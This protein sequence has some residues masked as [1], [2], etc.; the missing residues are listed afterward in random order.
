MAETVV[1]ADLPW[2]RF[3]KHLFAGGGADPEGLTR[4]AAEV[5]V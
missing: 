4:Y 3:R 2:D 1:L 5:L